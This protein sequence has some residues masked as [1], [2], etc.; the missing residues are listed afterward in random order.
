MS[1][2]RL[3]NLLYLW[4]TNIAGF[5]ELLLLYPMKGAPNRGPS[6]DFEAVQLYKTLIQVN[7]WVLTSYGLYSA[8]FST[9]AFNIATLR[10]AED[11]FLLGYVVFQGFL[12]VLDSIYASEG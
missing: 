2:Q 5:A 7:T 6:S 9:F 12:V 8:I 3:R 4:V 11:L 1:K 10:I